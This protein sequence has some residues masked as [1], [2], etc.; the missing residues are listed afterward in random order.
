MKGLQPLWR[1]PARYFPL[2][3]QTIRITTGRRICS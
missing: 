3:A 1:A 2:E